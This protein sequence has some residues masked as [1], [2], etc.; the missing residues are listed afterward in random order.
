LPIDD[1]LPEYPPPS[2]S[3]R[4]KKDIF[5]MGEYEKIED[6]ARWVGDQILKRLVLHSVHLVYKTELLTV[7]IITISRYYIF[8]FSN[9]NTLTYIH[10]NNIRHKFITT[11]TAH[12]VATIYSLLGVKLNLS[13]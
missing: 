11:L 5:K 12:F 1:I 10:F 7:Q 13:R 8:G 3:R 6:R 2:P 9:L 4:K